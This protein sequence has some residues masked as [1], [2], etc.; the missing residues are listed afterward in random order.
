MALNCLGDA[1][2]GQGDLAA[3]RVA[4]QAA[5]DRARAGGSRYEEAR[6]LRGLAGASDDPGTA[7]RYLAAALALY[8]LLN[9]PEAAQ[10][11]AAL[12][13]TDP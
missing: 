3:A 5:V 13:A 8:E 9:A 10:L 12:A 1:R 6:A 4:Y 7:R 2:S 11:R